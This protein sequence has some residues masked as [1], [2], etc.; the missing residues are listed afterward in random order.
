MPTTGESLPCGGTCYWRLEIRRP[1]KVALV[2]S[3][4]QQ[5]EVQRSLKSGHERQQAKKSA[6]GHHHTNLTA[7]M[8]GTSGSSTASPGGT[9]RRRSATCLRF[10]CRGPGSMPAPSLAPAVPPPPR[11]RKAAP[12]ECVVASN[13]SLSPLRPLGQASAS[14]RPLRRPGLGAHGDRGPLRGVI[15]VSCLAL[16][17]VSQG[18]N[19]LSRQDDPAPTDELASLA[20]ITAV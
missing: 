5:A 6:T 1:T 3:L 18:A 11:R 14:R 17:Q 7:P 10:S 19:H 9:N 12:P 13:T 2:G 20:V 15:D 16:G 4:T 8:P